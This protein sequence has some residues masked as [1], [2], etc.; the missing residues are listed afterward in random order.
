VC[1]RK[2]WRKK[3][4]ERPCRNR[5]EG[6]WEIDTRGSRKSGLSD[7]RKFGLSGFASIP[8]S[9]EA[10]SDNIDSNK[11]EEVAKLTLK[12]GTLNSNCQDPLELKLLQGSASIPTSQETGSA[13]I[14]P[15]KIN[16]NLGDVEKLPDSA[17][18]EGSDALVSEGG[19][20][21]TGELTR[22]EI[23]DVPIS[24]RPCD[25]E[26]VQINSDKINWVDLRIPP[27]SGDPESL[28]KLNSSRINPSGFGLPAEGPKIC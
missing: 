20:F 10:V 12:A 27:H 1:R 2:C 18:L 8:I 16:F 15:N 5:I 3:K 17:V 11:L 19:R 23:G 26:S 6:G 25:T 9:I 24:R 22:Y 4:R 13:I 21:P 7:C 28:A 14:N